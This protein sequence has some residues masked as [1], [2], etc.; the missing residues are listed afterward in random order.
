MSVSSPEIIAKQRLHAFM[1]QH[2]IQKAEWDGDVLVCWIAGM[3]LSTMDIDHSQAIRPFWV[4]LESW[5]KANCAS[6][7]EIAR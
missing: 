2:S 5:L 7:I 3:M 6:K 1:V 4:H